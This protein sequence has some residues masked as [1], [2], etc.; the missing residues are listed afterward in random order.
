[1]KFDYPIFTLGNVD[2]NM[3]HYPDF[4]EA[5]KIWERRKARINWYNLFVTGYTESEEVAREFDELPYGKKVCFVPFESDLDS[6][7]YISP[8]AD[9]GAKNFA[10]SIIRFF[11]G[12]FMY[13]DL[14]D[15]LL[16]GKKTPLIE[17]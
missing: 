4:D 14:F 17:M 16:Y 11:W 12:T 5:V 8:E 10:D 6:A 3:N 1:M 2:V 7:W 9:K 13:Y 15:M